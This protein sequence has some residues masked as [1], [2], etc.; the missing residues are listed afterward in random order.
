VVRIALYALALLIPVGTAQ[1]A[2]YDLTEYSSNSDYETDS[3]SEL[4]SELETDYDNEDTYLKCHFKNETEK[5]LI[6]RLI[7]GAGTGDISMML[8]A[9]ALGIDIN[10][11]GCKGGMTALS[12]AAS[13]GQKKTVEILLN[14]GANPEISTDY[15]D[16]A[17]TIA[18]KNN[19]PEIVELLVQA[20]ELQEQSRTGSSHVLDTYQQN[21]L[22][23]KLLFGAETG[24]INM[25]ESAIAEGANINARGYLNQTPLVLVFAKNNIN[26]DII[27][28]LIQA[29][30]D[31]NAHDIGG[32][33]ALHNASYLNLTDIAKYLVEKGADVNSKLTERMDSSLYETPLS[34]ASRNGNLELVE[35]LLTHNAHI[36]DPEQDN[37]SPALIMAIKAGSADI[38]SLLLDAGANIDSKDGDESTL[39]LAIRRGYKRITWLLINAGVDVHASNDTGETAISLAAELGFDDVVQQILTHKM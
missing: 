3:E 27:K 8:G 17:L 11:P 25:I 10:T 5:K 19:Y 23:E 34:L 15:G 35:Y 30:S 12:Y 32:W 20:Q 1:G 26:P 6:E 14:A 2:A 31:I 39:M 33:T 28:M 13:K 7:Y 38:V 18:A 16:T 36:N 37:Y 4:S 9:L 24:D 22:N 21:T 29:G